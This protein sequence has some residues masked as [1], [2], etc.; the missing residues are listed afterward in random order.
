VVAEDVID[1]LDRLAAA[2]LTAWVD[3]GWGV[4]ALLRA[5]TREHGD[6]D[7]VVLAPQLGEVR[8]V[9]GA[10]GYHRVV[11]DEMPTALTLADVHDREVDLHLVAPSGRGG[12][13][14]IL[15]DGTAFHYPPP[16][17]GVIGGRR[18]YCVDPSTQVRA[19]LGHPPSA[20][21]R[22]DLWRLHRRFG[23][24]YPYR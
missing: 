11:R 12:G 16:S 1:L 19:R 18:V 8:R 15:A 13:D 4:D 22:A 2:G 23:V 5:Q 17:Y 6:L 9:L 24:E 20:Q 14:Q 10:A 3:G 7:L 21:D